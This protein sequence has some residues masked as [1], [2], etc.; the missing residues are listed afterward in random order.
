MK[1]PTIVSFPGFTSSDESAVIR[2]C[3][4]PFIEFSTEIASSI[5]TDKDLKTT[6]SQGLLRSLRMEKSQYEHLYSALLERR[7][8]LRNTPEISATV[9]EFE[10]HYPLIAD[11]SPRALV[12]P[13]STSA[14]DIFEA[15]KCSKLGSA[16][17]IKTEKKSLKTASMV[18]ELTEDKLSECLHALN[19]AFAPFKTYVVKQILPLEAVDHRAVIY[20]THIAGFDTGPHAGVSAV[21]SPVFEFVYDCVGMLA[22]KGLVADYVLDVAKREDTG[23]FIIVEIKDLQFTQIKNPEFIW[24]QIARQCSLA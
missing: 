23:K 9:S 21:Q 4:F 12:F 8:R 11:A 6:E 14:H 15:I 10:L 16:V 17:F 7:I 20:G 24:A 18:R 22:R 19:E 5:T 3:G 2:K 1:T 13:S